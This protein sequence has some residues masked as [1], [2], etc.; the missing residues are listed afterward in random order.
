MGDDGRSGGIWGFLV[1][2][3]AALVWL[4]LAALPDIK[5]AIRDWWQRLKDA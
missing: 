5:S 3:G 2:Y 1:V 4:L